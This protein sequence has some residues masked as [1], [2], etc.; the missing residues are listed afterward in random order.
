M[1]KEKGE[2]ELT[3]VLKTKKDELNANKSNLEN[4]TIKKLQ[5][6]Q[7]IDQINSASLLDYYSKTNKTIDKYGE[8]IEK[9]IVCFK[10]DY[11]INYFFKLHSIISFI[12]ILQS[13]LNEYREDNLDDILLLQNR[14]KKLMNEFQSLPK[15]KDKE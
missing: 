1:A 9:I 5:S 7:K 10:E 15:L 8:K 4:N 13:K 12:F 11:K 3:E 14:T 2:K 6:K